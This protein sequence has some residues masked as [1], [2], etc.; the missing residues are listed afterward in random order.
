M[1]PRRAAPGFTLIE[2]A[3]A[4]AIAAGA[5]VV[6]LQLFTDG[7]RRADRATLTRLAVLTAQSA[8]ETAA[9][10]GALAPGARWGGTTAEGLAWQVAVAD[11][12][13]GGRAAAEPLL[14]VATVHGAGGEGPLL[15]RLATLRLVPVAE[16]ARRGP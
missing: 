1:P 9:V 7:G 12:P 2:V 10:Q 15:A 6:L 4:L 13:A 11:G 14:L 3:A 5:L 16:G 8:L